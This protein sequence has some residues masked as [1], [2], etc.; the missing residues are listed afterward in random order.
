MNDKWTEVYVGDGRTD[1]GRREVGIGDFYY[2][3]YDN[4]IDIRMKGK[5]HNTCP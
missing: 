4:F 5:P 3:F 2:G 1:V